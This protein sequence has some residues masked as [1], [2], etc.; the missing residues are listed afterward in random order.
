MFDAPGASEAMATDAQPETHSKP[1][2][3][4]ARKSDL[5]MISPFLCVWNTF[6]VT[7]NE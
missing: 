6:V 4:T 3:N 5:S 2:S 7:P 1:V